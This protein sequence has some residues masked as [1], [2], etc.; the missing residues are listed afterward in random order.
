MW[1]LRSAIA[2]TTAVT[3]AAS[4]VSGRQLRGDPAAILLAERMIE[5]LGGR[6]RWSSAKSLHIVE[7][8]YSAGADEPTRD[9]YRRDLIRPRIRADY[10]EGPLIITSTGSWRSDGGKVI[11]WDETRNRN[12]AR[13]WGS[14]IYVLYRRLAAKDPAIE[15]RL[16]Q[17]RSFAVFEG[18]LKIAV[19]ET[20]RGGA[21]VRWRRFA[22][23]QPGVVSEEWI[24]GPLQQFGQM[25]FPAWG[26]RIDGGERFYYREVHLDRVALPDSLFPAAPQ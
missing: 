15:I 25:S 19:F 2:L 6:D 21:P 4:P 16:E 22:A 18:G 8:S 9:V 17:E 3:L 13:N 12:F 7:E 20:T 1:R 14:N 10:P 11:R 24:Y 23:A 5:R 26:A